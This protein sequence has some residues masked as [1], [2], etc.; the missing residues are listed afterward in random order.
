MK[1]GIQII[2]K[3]REE[4]FLFLKKLIWNVVTENP[5]FVGIY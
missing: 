4:Q 2:L 3:F 5:F 1:C